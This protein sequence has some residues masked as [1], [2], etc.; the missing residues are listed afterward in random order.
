MHHGKSRGNERH[1]KY[2]K[3]VNILWNQGG[4]FAKVGGKEKFLGIGGKWIETGKLGEIRNFHWLKEVRNLADEKWKSG[5]FPR[6]PNLFLKIWGKCET[7]GNASLPHKICFKT[8]KLSYHVILLL[9]HIFI[10][11]Y[12]NSLSYEI[13]CY[14]I[15]MQ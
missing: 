4:N 10:I 9:V 3:R 7:G 11:A 15:H 1:V 6:S 13:T 2:V 5:K 14:V 8:G 12:S